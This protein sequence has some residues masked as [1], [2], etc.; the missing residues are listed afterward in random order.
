MKYIIETK[1]LKLRVMNDNDFDSLRAV[2]SDKETMKYYPKPYDDLGVRK[3]L[4]WCI[5]LDKEKGFCLWAVTLDDKFIG[6]C[7]ISIQNIDGKIVPEVGYHLNKNYWHQG[8]I[9]EASKAV[10][11]WFFENTDYDEV[12]SYMNA[13]NKPSINI[14]ISNGMSFRKKYYE[15]GVLHYVYSITREEYENGLLDFM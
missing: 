1:R 10:K 4:E 13:E 3:W 12:F 7:G 8:Y 6:D 9:S 14:A 11:K 5:N 2:I 15:D